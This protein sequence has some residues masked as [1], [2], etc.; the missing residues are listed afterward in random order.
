MRRFFFG[1]VYVHN[2]RLLSTMSDF[3]SLHKTLG[4]VKTLEKLILLTARF[5]F[6]RVYRYRLSVASPVYY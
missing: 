2:H 4:F 5:Y 3:I 6:L 1:L